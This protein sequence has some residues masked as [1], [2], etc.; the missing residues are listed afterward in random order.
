MASSGRPFN[1][2]RGTD[3]NGDSLFT[4]RPTYAEVNARCNAI[5][6]TSKFCGLDGI[7]DAN[8]VIPR[9]YGQSPNYFSVNLRVNKTFG[10]GGAKTAAAQ[11]NR[12]ETVGQPAQGR[13]R[14]R[15]RS[16]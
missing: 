4:E 5:G 16:R 12:T 13:T 3:T 14:N 11:T 2:I 6:L 9:N 10:F 7:A 1:I 8:A 15:G